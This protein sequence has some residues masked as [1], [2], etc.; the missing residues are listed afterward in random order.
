MKLKKIKLFGLN[1][2]NEDDLSYV[3]N[4][5]FNDLDSDAIEDEL[6]IVFTPNMDYLIKL[7]RPEN[8]FLKN[9]LSRS[10]YILP[11]GQPLIWASRFTKQTLKSRLTGSDLFPLMLQSCI[12]VR[13]PILLLTSNSKLTDFYNSIGN[14]IYAVT[15][16]IITEQNID[17]VS[18]S[19]KKII[20]NEVTKI[21]FIGVGFPNQDLLCLTIFNKL[22]RS[23]ESKPLICLF[24]A[25]LAFYAGHKKRAPKIYQSLGLE[26]AYRFMQEPNRLFKRYFIDSL[27][28]LKVLYNINK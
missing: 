27:G 23:K 5:I 12:D 24:G 18:E 15:L 20:V 4:C 17:Q 10:R 25:S 6:P 21:V 8:N 7:D 3:K 1:F 28:F 16:P 11:D 26:W 9:F 19:A 14:F 13:M 2:L 22:E